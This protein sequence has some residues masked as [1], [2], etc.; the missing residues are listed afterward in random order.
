MGLEV[1]GTLLEGTDLARYAR[2]VKPIV[3][4]PG[5]FGR[6]EFWAPVAERLGDLG[7]THLL[8]WPGFGG[9]PSDPTVHSLDDLYLYC[10]RSREA[11]QGGGV[12]PRASQWPARASSLRLI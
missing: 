5:A 11:I 10:T 2:R 4:L 12:S 1:D 9:I 6:A 3:F 8:S 7:P